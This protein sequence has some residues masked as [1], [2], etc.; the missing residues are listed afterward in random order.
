MANDPQY[1]D[2]S[3]KSRKKS[4]ARFS[5]LHMKPH[6]VERSKFYED[7]VEEM[8]RKMWYGLLVDPVQ[9]I[10][11]ALSDPNTWPGSYLIIVSNVYIF[12][13]LHIERSL[14]ALTMSEKSGYAAQMIN[15]GVV[16]LFPL[17]ILAVTTTNAV[18]AAM[19]LGVHTIIFMKLYSYHEVNRWLREEWAPLGLKSA[20]K[21]P[22]I[23]SCTVSYDENNTGGSNIQ[24][25]VIF[26]DNLTVKDLYYFLFAPT[27][28]YQMNFPRSSKI[29]LRFLLR[30]L[31]EMI[32]LIHLF[33]GLTQQWVLPV[34][35]NAMQPFVEMKLTTVIHQLMLIAIPN[36]FMW[37]ILFHGFFHSTLNLIAELLRFGD[38][39]FYRDWWNS[40]TLTYFWSNSNI[41]LHKWY[42]R[43]VYRP[44]IEKGYT[45]WEAQTSVFILS[46]LYHEYMIAAPLQIFRFWLFIEMMLQVP[47]AWFLSKFVRG[48]YGNAI[49]WVCII[50]GPPLVVYMYIHDYYVLQDLKANEQN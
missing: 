12:V 11:F 1:S 5:N 24:E 8:R 32:F 21:H 13:A 31:V 49:V 7:M 48:F 20:M 17:L 37:L 19:V 39:R 15:L 33:I 18:G 34:T 42:L 25:M 27:L 29:R 14:S 45:K 43:H 38:R 22:G 36:H 9:M 28:C 4:T 3:I 26:P 41:I 47:T 35:R 10:A 46:A 30:R 50:L 6:T 40:E 16:L 2:T 44:L 23:S